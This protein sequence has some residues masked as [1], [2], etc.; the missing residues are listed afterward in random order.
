M[1]IKS[2]CIILVEFTLFERGNRK[3]D[4]QIQIYFDHVSRTYCFMH[5]ISVH[6]NA[7]FSPENS[8]EY[9]THIICIL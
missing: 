7:F 3:Y 8:F 6:F 9:Y 2:V 5:F 4:N 1:Y